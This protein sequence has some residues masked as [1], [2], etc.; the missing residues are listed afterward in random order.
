MREKS[1]YFYVVNI[2]SIQLIA[3]LII[4][5]RGAILGPIWG[6]IFI[7]AGP[8]FMKV[9]FAAISEGDVMAQRYLSPIRDI[10]LG[11]LIIAFLIFL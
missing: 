8:E 6:A 3:A 11:S 2:L 4:G 5:G 1:C 9:L 10:A 7:V